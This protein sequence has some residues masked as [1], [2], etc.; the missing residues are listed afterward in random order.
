MK[1]VLCIL[2]SVF[3]LSALAS[4]SAVII[5]YQSG[6][7]ASAGS[8]GAADPAAQGWTGGASAVNGFLGAY[9][10]GDGGW[11]T[12]DG[13]KDGYANYQYNFTAPDLSAMDSNGWILTSVASMDSDALGPL[14]ATSNDYYLPPNQSRQNNTGMWIERSGQYRYI[15]LFAADANGNLLVD[16]GTTQHQITT[17]GSNGGY[18]VFTTFG[19]SYDGSSATMSA[20]GS[21]YPLSTSGAA[22]QDRILFG[23]H[24]STGQGSAIWNQY[25]L[26]VIPEP[27]SGI[28]ALLALGLFAF[29]HKKH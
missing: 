23:T 10:S 4:F 13:T 8:S 2:T 11:R 19:I 18:D 29:I 25:R 6:V 17:G 5:D 26:E 16:D 28:L 9:D 24:S 7:T 3:A 27:A 14:G 15:L 20:G 22:T 12:I 1:R 21:D